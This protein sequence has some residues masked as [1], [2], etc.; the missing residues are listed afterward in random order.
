[1]RHKSELS[2]YDKKERATPAHQYIIRRIREFPTLY[3]HAYAVIAASVLGT[4]GGSHWNEDGIIVN[5]DK[6]YDYENKT[7]IDYPVKIS[8]ELAQSMYNN[9]FG[10]IIHISDMSSYSKAPIDTIP[11][12]ADESWLEEIDSFLAHFEKFTPDVIQKLSEM[13]TFLHYGVWVNTNAGLPERYIYDY[14][15]FVNKIPSWRARIRS[16]KY[17]R[18]YGKIDPDT[19]VGMYI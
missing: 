12:N 9:Y 16:I 5:D 7:W 17:S 1:M 11:D 3:P 4:M 15:E 14:T 18:Y 8:E 19:F 10:K 13:R 2:E 6:Y